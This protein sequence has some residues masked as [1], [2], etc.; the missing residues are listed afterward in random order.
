[1]NWYWCLRHARVEPE[2]ACPH[3]QRLGPYATEEEAA[4]ALETAAARNEAW[5]SDP[6][7]D[8]DE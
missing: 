2:A 5:K 6:R 1:M 4:R 3:A 7:W 8:D